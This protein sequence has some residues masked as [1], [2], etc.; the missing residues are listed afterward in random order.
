MVT[1]ANWRHFTVYFLKKH[2]ENQIRMI[3]QD[4]TMMMEQVLFTFSVYF[5]I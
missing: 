2:N 5:P 4:K 3:T 1:R